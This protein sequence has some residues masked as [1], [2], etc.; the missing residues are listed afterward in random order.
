M[1]ESWEVCRVRGWECERVRRSEDQKIRRQAEGGDGN[2]GWWEEHSVKKRV[3]I[4]WLV[5]SL[6]EYEK[7]QS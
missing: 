2:F 7:D 3:L 5:E 4:R 6:I 1:V